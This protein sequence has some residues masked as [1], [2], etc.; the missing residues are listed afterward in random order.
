VPLRDIESIA[1]VEEPRKGKMTDFWRDMFFVGSMR[2]ATVILGLVAIKF[3]AVSFVETVKASAPFF[4]VGFAYVM[5][6]EKTSLKVAVTLVPVVSGL[7]LCSV[8]ELSFNIIGFVAAVTCNTVDCIQNVFSKKLLAHQ[9]T[10]VELQFY[11]SGAALVVQILLWMVQYM[12]GLGS[13]AAPGVAS[14]T[15]DAHPTLKWSFTLF[16]CFAWDGI[17]YHLQSVSVYTLMSLVSPVTVSVANTFKRAL[18]ILVSVFVFKNQVSTG[19][20]IGTFITFVG[21]LWYNDTKQKEG[22]SKTAT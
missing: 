21:V 2:C 19:A 14:S 1:L 20:G 16:L 15:D 22:K 18:L 12:Y 13:H 17:A 8:T 9:Y 5:L 10:P 4:T 3:V 7:V 11:T 6:G